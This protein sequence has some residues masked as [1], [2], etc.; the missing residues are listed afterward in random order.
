MRYLVTLIILGLVAVLAVG[1]DKSPSD[2]PAPAPNADFS[3]EPSSGEEPL[4]VNFTDRSI[5]DITGWEWDFGDGSTSTE[6]NPT[7]SYTEEGTY[8]VE[9]T[10]NG[11]GGSDTDT[12]IDHIAV[13]EKSVTPTP[14]AQEN[15]RFLISDDVNAIEDFQYLYVNISSIG[16]RQGGESGQWKQW[17]LDIEPIDLKPL[18]GVKALEIWSGHLDVGEYSKVFVY[19]NNVTGVLVDAEDGETVDV[20]LPSNKLQ[21]SKPFVVAEDSV[22]SFVYDITVVAAGN[23]HSGIK[24]ILRPQIGQS[25][26]D[27]EFEEVELPDKP[28]PELQ[29]Q[30][31]GDTGPGAEVSIMV[32]LEGAPVGGATVTV[33]GEVVGSTDPDGHLTIVLP[34]VSGEVVIQATLGDKTGELELEIGEEEGQLEWFE[35]TISAITAGEENSS[36]WTMTL[37]GIEGSVTV[38]VAELQGTPSVGAK[39]K[40][41]G[42]LEGNVIEG[43]RAELEEEEE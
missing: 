42:I 7:H 29:I 43:A 8:T 23:Q 11:P 26:A 17:S 35:G 2:R 3:A 27:K 9:L 39:A 13:T 14:G 15:F 37:E 4:E 1:C 36:P 31:D 16:V 21:I 19:V 22:T 33:N 41:E 30:L 12:R 18:V 5:G 38:Y 25:G 40:I 24:Y 6:R 28:E 10:V 34:E 20:M 32:T